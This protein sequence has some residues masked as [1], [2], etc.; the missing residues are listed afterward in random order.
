VSGD[1]IET[2]KAVALKSGILKPEEAS[3]L[4]SVMSAEDF[5]NTVGAIIEDENGA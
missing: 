4:Y 5:R 2:A 3:K 1:H